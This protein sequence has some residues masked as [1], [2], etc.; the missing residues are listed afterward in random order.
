VLLLPS[1]RVKGHQRGIDGA[2]ADYLAS[3]FAGRADA[4]TM[5]PRPVPHAA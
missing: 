5:T 2:A 1:A 4:L 3:N